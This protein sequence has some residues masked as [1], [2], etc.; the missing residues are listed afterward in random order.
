MITKL[1]VSGYRSLRDLT[2]PL[3]Q[4]TLV[5]GANGTGKSSLYRALK[6]L[7]DVAQGRVVQ[8]LAGEGGLSSTLWA[9]PEAISRNV[10]LGLLPVQGTRRKN[11]IALKLG[12]A[13]KDFG[14]AIDLGLPPPDVPPRFSRDPQIKLEA[15]W[16]GELLTRNSEFAKRIN[17]FV[18]IRDEAGTWRDVLQT[19]NTMDSMMTHCAD[20]KF[21]FELL[22]LR[23][24]M[25]GWRFYDH[26]RTD[27]DAPARRPQIGTYTPVLADDGS[28]LAAAIAT[29]QEIG[30][31]AALDKAIED[32]FPGSVLR[33][34]ESGGYFELEMRQHGLLRPLKAAELSDGT[35]RYLIWI[36]ALLSPRSTTLM[37]LNEPETSLH[38][39]LVEPLSRLI[40][41]ASRT[42]Q[43]IVISHN[44][45]LTKALGEQS[46][47][48][49]I[50][51]LKQ[52]GETLT[53][54]DDYVKWN[55][56]ER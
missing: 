1:S 50:A 46:H 3:G 35:L 45:I 51:L 6:L 42:T 25:R 28:D 55:W 4:I 16:N 33:I 41:A 15:L 53:E 27:R 14:Y 26:V 44:P 19:L 20:P 17:N 39:D 5:T 48:Q 18:R 13:G 12:F 32:A 31:S 34:V 54:Q 2:L 29:V 30:D 49:R 9:G 8:S 36:A 21:G 56:P 47:V 11:A 52:F 10:K 23:E 7:A 37:V 40:I 24:R 38:Q 22:A 43:L